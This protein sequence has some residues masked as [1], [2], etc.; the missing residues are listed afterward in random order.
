MPTGGCT[1][2]TLCH[3]CLN[4]DTPPVSFPPPREHARPAGATGLARR[5]RRADARSS[6]HLWDNLAAKPII[7][8]VLI[9]AESANEADYA[10]ALAKAGYQLHIREPGWYEHRMFKGPEN[11]VNLHVFS[12]GCT[13]IDRMLT[14][15]DWL[16]TSKSDRRVV[17]PIQTGFGATGVEIHSEL[18]RREDRPY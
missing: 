7:D 5:H 10:V 9:V 15:Q 16:R 1:A 18:C 4:R 13:E 2:T 12:A 3:E 17:C 14:F 6:R 8:I 11:S